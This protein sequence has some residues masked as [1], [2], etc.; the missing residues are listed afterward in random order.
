[1]KIEHFFKRGI[2]YLLALQILEIKSG[3]TEY[4]LIIGFCF[5]KA[6]FVSETAKKGHFIVITTEKILL[7][8][9]N[10]ALKS[11]KYY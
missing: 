10:I 6:I 5:N 11:S 7:S 9:L 4:L 8:Y 1:M 2:Y 3:Y